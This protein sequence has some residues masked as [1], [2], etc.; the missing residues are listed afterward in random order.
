M[1]DFFQ[2]RMNQR[3]DLTDPMKAQTAEASPA[4]SSGLD[5][6]QVHPSFLK[7]RI[8]S[9]Q[10]NQQSEEGSDV[11]AVCL[12]LRLPHSSA[13]WLSNLWVGVSRIEKIAQQGLE[14]TKMPLGQDVRASCSLA[15]K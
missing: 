9:W 5:E 12:D 7:R 4:A 3:E 6:G 11:I 14:N 10:L 15:K 2:V 8:N 13:L 1:H